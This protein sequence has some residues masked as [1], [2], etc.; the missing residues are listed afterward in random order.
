[1]SKFLNI[2]INVNK[3]FLESLKKKIH[4]F[5]EKKCKKQL[6]KLIIYYFL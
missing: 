2:V 5:Y 6:R 1:M 4:L 3:P